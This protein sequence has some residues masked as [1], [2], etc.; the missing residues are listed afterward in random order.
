MPVEYMV[1]GRNLDLNDKIRD[2]SEKKIKNRIEKFLD[3]TTKV[4]VKFKQE[5]NPRINED[6]EVE[7]TVFASGSVI[8]VTDNGND[9]TEAIDRA[10]GKLERQIKKYRDK[11]IKRGRKNNIKDTVASE[12]G[13]FGTGESGDVEE[14]IKRSIVKNKTFTLKPISPEEAVI[15][16]ELLG[17]DFFVFINAESERTA[18]VYRRK[19]S[20][21]GLIE[22]TI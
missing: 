1:K 2:Y 13:K 3:R 16:M 9:F 12:I 19:D 6:K 18:V 14:K 21:Y 11:L 8:R 15:Q 20:N 10:A 7:I 17:H 4:E 22:P 5:N